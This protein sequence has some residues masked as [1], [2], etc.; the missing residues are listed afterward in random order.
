GFL[1][2]R[3]DDLARL[4]E[5][6][7][8]VAL[9]DL[10]GTGGTR[11]GD[12]RGRNSSATALAS[13]ELMLGR[14]LLGARLRD[15]RSVLAHRR[16]RADLDPGRAAGR[17]STRGGWPCGATRAP[18]PTRPIA[19]W[20]CPWTSPR[21]RSW[22]SRWGGCWRC[23]AGCTRTRCASSTHAADWSAT[24]LCSRAPSARC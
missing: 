21:R 11:P 15:L 5:G 7:V 8:A 12:G 18:R 24:R 9:P 3:A 16:G 20:R 1:K 19:T 6:G 13:S 17:T 14:T 2:E 23:W 4:L 22:P 10:R